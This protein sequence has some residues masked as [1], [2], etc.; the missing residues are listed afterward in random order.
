MRYMA[1][2]FAP[3]GINVNA[4]N[5]GIIESDS[6]AYFYDVEGMPDLE[7]ERAAEDPEGSGM[8]TVK[9]VADTVEFLLE[10]RSEYITGQSLVVD[11][12][13]TIIAPP[14]FDDAT[15]PLRL[16]DADAGA[17]SDA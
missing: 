4:V 7:R 17:A 8:G 9:E 5:G 14:F 10:P 1:V 15:G 11:G 13:L 12:G 2:E 6:S 16:P 3:L